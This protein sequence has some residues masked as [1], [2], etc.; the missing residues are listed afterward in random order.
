MYS[1]RV[2][3]W[4]DGQPGSFSEP[5]ALKVTAD[6]P[7]PTGD[8]NDDGDID[9][10]DLFQFA[11]DWLMPVTPQDDPLQYRMDINR[12]GLI[13][14]ADLNRY[15]SDRSRRRETALTAPS[16]IRPATGTVWSQERLMT[17]VNQGIPFLLW[18]PVDGAQLYDYEIIGFNHPNPQHNEL[19]YIPNVR[20][21]PYLTG[22]GSLYTWAVYTGEW[23][24]RV[25]GRS[26]IGRAG[27]WS[28]WVSFVVQ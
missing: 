19:Q 27:P 2:R 14:G 16:V 18:T 28:P 10:R 4:K 17:W 5:R 6:F 21:I 23:D 13:D 26:A 8:V 11:A 9:S 12:N 7:F 1:W 25:R 24:M 20:G 15:A 3:A 22:D